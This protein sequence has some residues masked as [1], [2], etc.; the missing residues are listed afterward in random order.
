MVI[1]Y[2]GF[3]YCC[4]N[5]FGPHPTECYE[6]IWRQVGCIEQGYAFPRNLTDIELAYMSSFTVRYKKFLLEIQ[7]ITIAIALIRAFFVFEVFVQLWCRRC[8]NE[9]RRKRTAIY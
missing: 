2:V 6:A 5:F 1:Y 3:P 9:E 7:F 4:I 8:Q